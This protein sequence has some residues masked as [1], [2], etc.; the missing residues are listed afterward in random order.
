MEKSNLFGFPPFIETGFES[1]MGS[2]I[3]HVKQSNNG[4]SFLAFIDC[5]PNDSFINLTK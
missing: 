4:T 5:E 1:D 2:L 3:W